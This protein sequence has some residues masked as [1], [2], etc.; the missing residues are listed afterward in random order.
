MTDWVKDSELE[1]YG[2]F[3][4]ELPDEPTYALEPEGSL[5]ATLVRRN[6][7]TTGRAL[8]YVHG[9]NDYFFQ[10]HL[11]DEV[12]AMGYDFYALD[13]RRYGRSLRPRQ[14]AGYVAKLDD[15]FVELDAAVEAIRGEGHDELVLMGHST[16]GLVSV[17]Y[18]DERPGTFSGLILNSPWLEVQAN[19][20]LRSTTQPVFSAAGALAPTTA[21]PVGDAGFYLRTIRADA[22]GEWTYN[23]NLKG[24]PA[25]LIRLGWA[26]AILHGHSRVA[27]GLAIDCPI[28]VATSRRTDFRRVWDESLKSADSVLDVERIADRASRLGDLV[29]LA[30]ID[31]GLHDLVLSRPEVRVEVFRQFAVFLKAYARPF[32]ERERTEEPAVIGAAVEEPAAGKA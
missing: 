6:P 2:Q 19:P 29:V 28:L 23:H 1:G 5:V 13:L 17:L 32:A 26:A 3:T 4:I 18:A 24:D 21:L 27:A 31:G 14:L 25:F 10:S 16:G 12:A 11:G 20:M 22:D 9:W 7:P 15:Y 30:R 8:L